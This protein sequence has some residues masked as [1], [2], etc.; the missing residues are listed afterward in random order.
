[1]MKTVILKTLSSFKGI[2]TRYENNPAV[3]NCRVLFF[4]NKTFYHNILINSFLTLLAHYFTFKH[5]QIYVREMFNDAFDVP[6]S[7]PSFGNI[8]L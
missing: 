7:K 6:V 8:Y 5:L 1:M 2:C 4:S 3:I